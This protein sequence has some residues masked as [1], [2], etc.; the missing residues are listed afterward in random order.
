MSFACQHAYNCEE[1]QS[2]AHTPSSPRDITVNMH[3][4]SQ[5]LSSDAAE[6]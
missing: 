3:Y 6:I 2:R 5:H 1:D 4:W